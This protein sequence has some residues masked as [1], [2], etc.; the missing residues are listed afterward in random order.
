MAYRRTPHFAWWWGHRGYTLF[1]VRELTSVF[2]GAYAVLLLML[3]HRL[4]QGRAAYEAYLQSLTTP[5]M[6]A[7]HIVALAAAVY[8][9][10]TWFALSPKAMTVRLAGRPLPARVIVG[11]NVAAWL[12][13]SVIVAWIIL[14]G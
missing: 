8:H 5:W 2:I 14:R 10:V 12:A 1:V 6:I 3:V 9:S 13:V 4:G 7:F 11:A